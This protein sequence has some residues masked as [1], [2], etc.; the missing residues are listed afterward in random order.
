MDK[1]NDQRLA[2]FHKKG[3]QFIR[4]AMVDTSNI[5][6]L[7]IVPI[8]KFLQFIDSVTVSG[9]FMSTALLGV[10]VHEDHLAV[11]LPP[12][13]SCRGEMC[14]V[15]DLTSGIDNL[16][17]LPYGSGTHAL[18]MVDL[19]EK[20][21]PGVRFGGCARSSLKNILRLAS[22]ELGLTFLVGFEIEVVF[23]K[24]P[25]DSIT[26]IDDTTYASSVALHSER[27]SMMIDEIVQSI[28]AQGIQVSHFHGESGPG[29]FEFVT[30]PYDPLTAADNLVRTRET[31]Y[32]IAAK[33]DVKATMAPKVFANYGNKVHSEN[34]VLK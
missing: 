2:Q 33:Y 13:I 20:D 23:L 27:T 7:R 8:S 21:N 32:N 10:M 25:F 22:D 19:E 24:N 34:L 5:V 16:H 6:R 3:I 11:G 1:M 29:Q 30:D 15:P 4:M 28:L 17:R 9:Y 26:P 18:C 31:I 14:L 12:T